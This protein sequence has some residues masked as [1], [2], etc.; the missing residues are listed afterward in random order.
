MRPNIR[1]QRSNLRPT[2]RNPPLQLPF[3]SASFSS[4]SSSS[5]F[6]PSS[7]I[8][9]YPSLRPVPPPPPLPPFPCYRSFLLFLLLLLLFLLLLFLPLIP[10]SAPSPPLATAPSSYYYSSSSSAF[11]HTLLLARPSHSSFISCSLKETRF[12][13]TINQQPSTRALPP[14]H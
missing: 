8:L 11:R 6:F 5:S 9:P 10:P 7:I 1:G 4:A 2:E 14:S 3:F 12:A 13:L